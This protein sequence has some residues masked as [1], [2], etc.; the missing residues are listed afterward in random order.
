MLAAAKTRKPRLPLV[1]EAT[2]R[3]DLAEAAATGE[4]ATVAVIDDKQ[5]LSNYVRLLANFPREARRALATQ[6]AVSEVKPNDITPL[7]KA[8]ISWII[9]RQDR[10]WYAVGEAKARLLK[11]GQTE[12]QIYALDGDW[13]EF[14]T[15]DR[16]L[17]TVA[18]Q[19]ASTPV[20]LTDAEVNEAL[21]LT[22]PRQVVQTINYTTQRAAFDRVTE[23]AGLPVEP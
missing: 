18:R 1:D 2:A 14:T 7:Q 8:Q 6:N 23:A 21:K 17:F 13:K 11:L 4:A 3:K 9:A 5:S 22:G 12:D 10:A 16:S 20:V 15:A 19:L